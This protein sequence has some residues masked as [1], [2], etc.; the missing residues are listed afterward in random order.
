MRN[1]R[2]VWDAVLERQFKDDERFAILYREYPKF[3][4]MVMNYTNNGV[5]FREALR[6]VL[7]VNGLYLPD[8]RHKTLFDYDGFF[9]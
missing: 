8:E 3:Y 2:V 1:A 5:T 7:A 6:K 9:D 4:N